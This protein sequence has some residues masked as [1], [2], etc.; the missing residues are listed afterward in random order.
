MHKTL[1]CSSRP[2]RCTTLPCQEKKHK[3]DTSEIRTRDPNI[4]RLRLRFLLF[5][6][7]A[8]KKIRRICV[9]IAVVIAIILYSFFSAVFA[10]G[11]TFSPVSSF[12]F[13]RRI[14]GN[15]FLLGSSHPARVTSPFPFVGLERVT[16]VCAT[17]VRFYL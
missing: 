17:F 7:Q 4:T 1:R 2:E 16:D 12:F 6:V 8:L 13:P 5:W 3:G 14:R 11:G 9:F 15:P 10:Q